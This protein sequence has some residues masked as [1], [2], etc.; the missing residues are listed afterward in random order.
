MINKPYASITSKI[1]ITTI[2]VCL[3][4][5]VTLRHTEA[6]AN[7][8]FP[9]SDVNAS[10]LPLTTSSASFDINNEQHIVTK[11]TTKVPLQQGDAVPPP[12]PPF[13]IVEMT[14][15][16]EDKLKSI[17]N[18]E[19]GVPFV[20]E[21]FDTMEFE[22]F[23][24]NDSRLVAEFA[25]RLTVKLNRAT[26]AINETR[27]SLRKNVFSTAAVDTIS[28]SYSH[29]RDVFLHSVIHPC[30]PPPKDDL[31][32]LDQH[33]DKQ[34]IEIKNWPKLRAGGGGH[35]QAIVF[36]EFDGINFTANIHVAD[37]IR[38][39]NYSGE[40]NFRQIYF[41]SRDDLAAT[42]VSLSSGAINCRKD[43]MHL[44]Y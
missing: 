3:I 17:R 34:Q 9:T 7:V 11:P 20:Q 39:V 33:Y 21:I 10:K 32:L 26:R 41:L 37:A 8:Y 30:R 36:D 14:H 5:P 25:A 12:P 23:H 19:L 27:R 22:V 2:V 18:S 35:E 31:S 6:V 40:A 15:N 43:E 29:R 38:S 16:L 42:T 13:S 4:G 44:R 28:S 24:R 1:W